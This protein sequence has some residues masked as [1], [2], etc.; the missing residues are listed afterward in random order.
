MVVIAY[1]L[2]SYKKINSDSRLYQGINLLGALFV[3]IYVFSQQAWPAVTLQ[4]VWGIIAI[5]ALVK[6]A[7]NKT[8]KE[9]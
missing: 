6:S 5:S 9:L 1:F 3:G 4:V 8:E 2:V 7:T